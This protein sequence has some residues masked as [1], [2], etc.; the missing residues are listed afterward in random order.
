[1]DGQLKILESRKMSKKSDSKNI[2]KAVN[3]KTLMEK[4]YGKSG[5]KKRKKND[6]KLKTIIQIQKAKYKL[7]L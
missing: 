5:T 4:S 1:M 3:F 7:C 6:M 2:G